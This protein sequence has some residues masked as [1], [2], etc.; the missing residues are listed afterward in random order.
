MSTPADRVTAIARATREQRGRYASIL[1]VLALIVAVVGLVGWQ[2]SKPD[3]LQA[4]AAGV[5]DAIAA[6]QC[7]QDGTGCDVKSAVPHAQR[8]W[9]YAG[10]TAAGALL[11]VAFLLLA[12]R[13]ALPPASVERLREGA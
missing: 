10:G 8:A 5:V 3:E 11:V 1:V 4:S 9:L 6:L 7:T 12:T 2:A 13:P